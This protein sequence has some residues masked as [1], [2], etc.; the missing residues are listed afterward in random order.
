MYTYMQMYRPTGRA[1]SLQNSA[2]GREG[3]GPRACMAPRLVLVRLGPD[4]RGAGKAAGKPSGCR[5]PA[6]FLLTGQ[7]GYTPAAFT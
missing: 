6:A 4:M 3:P 7:T 5:F 1:A 2:A